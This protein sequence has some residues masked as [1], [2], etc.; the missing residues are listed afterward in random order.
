V[1]VAAVAWVLAI[2]VAIP[3]VTEPLT[4]SDVVWGLSFLALSAVGALVLSRQSGNAFGWALL[5]GSVGIAIGVLASD[6]A[7]RI[8]EG[9]ASW[10]A[11]IWVFLAGEVVFPVALTLLLAAFHRFPDGEVLAG[12]G[13]RLADRLVRGLVVVSGAVVLFDRTPGM[14]FDT[15]PDPDIFWPNP[16]T[17]L[18]PLPDL[19]AIANAVLLAVLAL[20]ITGF[21]SLFVRYRKGSVTVRAQL[22][23]VLLPVVTGI[24]LLTP[25]LIYDALVA[26]PLPDAIE[27]MGTIVFTLGIPAGIFMAITKTGLY[28]IDRLIRRT[29]AYSVVTAILV[30]VYAAAVLG[31][32]QVMAWFGATGNDVIVALSTLVA[33]AMARPLLTTVRRAIDRRFHRA[34]RDAERMID[35]FRGRLRDD[36]SDDSVRDGLIQAVDETLA[37]QFVTIWVRERASAGSGSS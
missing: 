5:L 27:A 30:T 33:A 17:R 24:G 11:G 14:R 12:R 36:V 10:P 31:I 4:W 23:W 26:D 22:R 8:G 37:P 16:L 2:A 7:T 6:Y 28:E 20:G 9:T 1:V 25:I 18:V 34:G 15:W 21:A 13:W 32:G 19:D 35:A 3:R 29:V